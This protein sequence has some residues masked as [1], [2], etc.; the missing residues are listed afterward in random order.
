[1]DGSIESKETADEFT[2]GDERYALS[3]VVARMTKFF[4][5]SRF[6]RDDHVLTINIEAPASERGELLFVADHES[7]ASARA[8]RWGGIQSTSRPCSRSRTPTGA[9]RRPPSDPGYREG[10]IA[11]Q[12]TI[13]L[14]LFDYF[15]GLGREPITRARFRRAYAGLLHTHDKIPAGIQSGAKV[16][17]PEIASRVDTHW[18]QAVQ[19][20]WAYGSGICCT[21][22]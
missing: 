4:D 6:P 12:V 17:R 7:S 14:S 9:P 13:S 19:L 18:T 11:T 22:R 3:R 5:V 8:S 21:N 16:A 1:M 20:T 15:A 2:S 10:A